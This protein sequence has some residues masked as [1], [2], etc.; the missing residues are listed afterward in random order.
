[1]NETICL[2]LFLPLLSFLILVASSKI[3]SRN[4]TCIIACGSILISFIC[5]FSLLNM[6]TE[7]G[8][9]SKT[10]TLF[11]WIKLESI[12]ADFSLHLDHLSLLMTLIIS[13]VGFL[14]HVYSIGYTDHETDFVRY[15]AFLN[16]FIFMM[17][18]LV[19]SS[20]LL[21]MFVGWEGV[22]L[23]S[24][25]LIGYWYTKETAA[26]A[27][28]KAFVVN[29]IGDL[30]FLLGILLTFYLFQTTD[31][32]EITKK[33]VSQ[34]ASGDITIIVLTL[35][36]FIGA[37]GKSAQI[38]LHTWLP[39]AMAGPT[40]V[41]ALIHAATMVT[42][43]VYLIVRLHV[44]YLM[45]PFTLQ[46]VGVIGGITALYA[47]LSAIAQTDLKKVLA[48]STV[49]QLGFMF[50][51]CGAGAFYSAMFH[52]TMHAFIKGLLFLSAGNVVHM[53]HGTTE[54]A[55][56]GGLS[57]KFPVTN[58]LFLIGVLALSGAPP[59]AA[60]FSKDLI[61]EQ[62]YLT[63]CHTLFYI[64]LA[65]SILTGVYL[66]RAYLLTFRGELSKENESDKTIQE[67]PIVMLVPVSILSILAIGGG[68]LGA[69]F[70]KMPILESFLIE[71]GISPAEETLS[72][73]F[74]ASPES[75]MA[76]FGAFIG[77]GVPLLLYTRFENLI[78]Q[79]LNFLTKAFYVDELYNLII[80]KPLI[81]TSQF[82]KD[83][84]E[85]K[86]FEGV[87][88]LSGASAIKCGACLQLIQNGQIR[89]YV[90]I[91]C[92]GAELLI[93]YYML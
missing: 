23:A 5:F 13:G 37:I 34:F 90:A 71:V 2:G 76:I 77:I 7:Q 27:A 60:F 69:T 16:F 67:A 75:F 92:I 8:V 88:D 9:E 39:D 4:Q 64:G 83:V 24:Y 38:P 58:W 78:P 53:M 62:E 30:G 56:M 22:G 20:N 21:L 42:A 10:V 93:V 46:V 61:L 3:L 73:G 79:R 49:S 65:A 40:P 47:A 48:Y 87:M 43:G 70:G 89:S 32:E 1:M 55:K 36:L 29:R 82:V 35:L 14:I 15:F 74:I 84:S 91:M 81:K 12:S 85:P 11:H 54:M 6:F 19:L 44:L 63:G 52:L 57:K 86:L 45:A 18:L 41:S 72:H 26:K 28:T 31:I 80:V 68:F 51:A 33:A 59:L 17:L 66:M 25:L 50:L